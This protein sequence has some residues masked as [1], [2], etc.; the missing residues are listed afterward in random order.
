MRRLLKAI[1]RGEE[2]TQDVSTLENPA[3]LEQLR[4]T[5]SVA[6]PA[7]AAS[8]AA[9]AGAAA[10][11]AVRGAARRAASRRAPTRRRPARG[12]APP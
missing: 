8:K 6:A 12:A 5:D 2:I 10:V 11:A 9:V 7:R 1:A 4:G 3:I